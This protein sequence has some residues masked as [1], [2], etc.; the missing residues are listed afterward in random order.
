MVIGTDLLPSVRR[1]IPPDDKEISAIR[2]E[3]WPRPSGPFP[4]PQGPV[5]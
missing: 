5:P 4:W 3:V 1:L 2:D